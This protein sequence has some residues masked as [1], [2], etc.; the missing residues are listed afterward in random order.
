MRLVTS[1]SLVTLPGEECQRSQIE[2]LPMRRLGQPVEIALYS[3]DLASSEA[4]AVPARTYSPTMATRQ[5]QAG[6][7]VG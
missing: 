2:S 6:T 7:P 3:G 1:M 5:V 4:G